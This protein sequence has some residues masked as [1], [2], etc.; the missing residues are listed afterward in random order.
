MHVK[1]R[2]KNRRIKILLLVNFFIMSKRS[3]NDSDKDKEWFPYNYPCKSLTKFRCQAADVEAERDASSEKKY[4]ITF[5]ETRLL[6]DSSIDLNTAL[7]LGLGAFDRDLVEAKIPGSYFERKRVQRLGQQVK[8]EKI[9]TCLYNFRSTCPT[10]NN[11]PTFTLRPEVRH[12]ENAPSRSR[13]PS[14]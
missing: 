12:Q 14:N 6:V 11:W 13:L 2:T 10:E 3:K 4:L 8:F 1:G 7:C 5:M 9:D